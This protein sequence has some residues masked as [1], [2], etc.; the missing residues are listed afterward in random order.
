MTVALKA[1]FPNIQE[2]MSARGFAF[3]HINDIIH[4]GNPSTSKYRLPICRHY[5][6]TVRKHVKYT[7]NVVQLLNLA[8]NYTIIVLVLLN[9]IE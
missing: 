7:V 9:S 6:G 1:I 5:L 8:V 4:V 2:I 3:Y